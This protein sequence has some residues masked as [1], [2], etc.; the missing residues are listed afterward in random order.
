MF[1]IWLVFEVERI[2][3]SVEVLLK[4]CLWGKEIKGRENR[5]SSQRALGPRGRRCFNKNR[6]RCRLFSREMASKHFCLL[7]E[8]L[9][10]EETV[11]C[12]SEEIF[13]F[14]K[15]TTFKL[16]KSVNTAHHLP[17]VELSNLYL[18]SQ[19]NPLWLTCGEMYSQAGACTDHVLPVWV[20]DGTS[21]ELNNMNHTDGPPPRVKVILRMDTQ[22]HTNSRP[23]ADRPH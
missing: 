10:W 22:A 3:T 17:L 15:K 23:G 21:A 12:P 14:I 20:T 19:S 4:S 9:Q 16:Y 11:T 2:F 8:K 6:C 1:A 5:P 7:A 13:L 18:W